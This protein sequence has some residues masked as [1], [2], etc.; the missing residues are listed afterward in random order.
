MPSS[1]ELPW[2][3]RV[4]HFI[5]NFFH[6]FRALHPPALLSASISCIP[7]LGSPQAASLLRASPTLHLSNISVIHPHTPQSICKYQES[8][9]ITTLNS[10]LHQCLQYP[11]AARKL[12]WRVQHSFCCLLLL[13]RCSLSSLRFL[14]RPF[15]STEVIFLHRLLSGTDSLMLGI[16][17]PLLANPKD[18]LH[19]CTLLS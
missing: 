13:A 5:H 6:L 14:P 19:H 17:E 1:N 3:P 4:I 16:L 15:Q 9:L 18:Q 8:L 12:L 7:D 2:V 10:A 11:D